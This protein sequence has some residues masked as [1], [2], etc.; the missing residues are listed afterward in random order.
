[1]SDEVEALRALVSRV[2]ASIK[3][4][5]AELQRRIASGAFGPGATIDSIC[6]RNG[7]PYLLDMHIALLGARVALVNAC[8]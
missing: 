5:E 2:E 1:M 4:T 8:K 7:R 6:D 3:T